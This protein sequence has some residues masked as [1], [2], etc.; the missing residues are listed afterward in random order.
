MQAEITYPMQAVFAKHQTET[1]RIGR[2]VSALQRSGGEDRPGVRGGGCA[3]FALPPF[4]R[5]LPEML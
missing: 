2:A 3:R 5:L 4:F 1:A